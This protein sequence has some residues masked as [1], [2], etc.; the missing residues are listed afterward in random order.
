M[1]MG[2]GSSVT[3]R[4]AEAMRSLIRLWDRFQRL[5]LA[6]VVSEISLVASVAESVVTTAMVRGVTDLVTDL[7]V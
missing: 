3:R 6:W 1:V 5:G 7:W 2:K 4:D